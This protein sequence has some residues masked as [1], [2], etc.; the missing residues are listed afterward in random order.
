MEH[1]NSKKNNVESSVHEDILE[2]LMKIAEVDPVLRQALEAW[3]ELS[4]SE[5]HRA[6]YNERLKQLESNE[7]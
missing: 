3:E 5:E 6:A 1:E 7:D 4:L 2:E